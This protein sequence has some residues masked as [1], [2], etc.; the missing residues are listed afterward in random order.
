MNQESLTMDEKLA[1][2]AQ[3]VQLAVGALHDDDGCHGMTSKMS[4]LRVLVTPAR[5]Q[6]A[7][8]KQ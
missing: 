2:L 7:I 1:F 6:P 4:S 3:A 5:R 8:W